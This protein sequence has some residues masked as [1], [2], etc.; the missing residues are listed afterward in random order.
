MP[1]SVELYI[2]IAHRLAFWFMLAPVSHAAVVPCGAHFSLRNEV[3]SYRRHNLSI[4][5]YLGTQ[6]RLGEL[7]G[8]EL[9]VIARIRCVGLLSMFIR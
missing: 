1:N 2:K 4:T 5:F 8:V 6:P 3:L 7:S 9:S